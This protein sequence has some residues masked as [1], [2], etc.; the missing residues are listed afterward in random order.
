VRGGSC[1]NL[2]ECFGKGTATFMI[3]G[4]I[5]TRRCPF[6]RRR[7]RPPEFHSTPTNRDKLGERL[8]P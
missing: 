6:L 1:P 8:P 5:C 7:A 4:D 2:G 3:M